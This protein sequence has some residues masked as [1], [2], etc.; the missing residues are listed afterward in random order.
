MSANPRIDGVPLTNGNY[1]GVFYDSSGT[2][3]CGGYE[4]WTA[5]T[6]ISVAAFGDDPLTPGKDGF[7]NNELFCWKIWDHTKDTVV[8]GFAEYQPIGY[9]GYV[10]D[11]SR[12][13]TNGI[14]Q[15]E[16][17]SLPIQLASFAA[18][19]VDGRNVKLEWITITE[20]NNYGFYV[21]RRAEG[22]LSY[23]EVPN[24]FVPGQG[25][26]LEPHLYSFVD[27]ISHSG[28]WY[29][30]LR[31]VDLNGTTNYSEEIKVDIVLGVKEK[32]IPKKYGLE[33]AYPSPFNP[34]TT[35]KYELSVDSRV[36]L[37]VYNILGKEV[38][39][40][41]DEVQDAGYKSVNFYA[42]DIASGVYFYRLEATSISDPSKSFTQVKKMLLLK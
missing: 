41:V 4:M 28:V 8:D 2:L 31:Q 21:E 15:I 30:R 18:S 36:I 34:S 32:E 40:I 10:S 11:T 12:Y 24:S 26:T 20:V 33:Q 13:S 29:Y 3:K 23:T 14:S 17:G 38:R 25:T 7:A 42:S 9:G 16:D 1:I 22:T 5:T 27:T 39:T 19:V 35:I 6:N 37:K